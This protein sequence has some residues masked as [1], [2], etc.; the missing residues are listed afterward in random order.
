[1]PEPTQLSRRALLRTAAAASA[2]LVAGPVV[3]TALTGTPAAAATAFVDDYR[4][5]VSGNVT[6]ETNAAVRILAG[7]Q[8]LWHTG[9]AWNTGTVLDAPALHA[10][11]RY[12]I[13]VTRNRTD[14]QAARAFIQDRQ[15]QSYAAISGLGPL[16]PV[17]KAGAL[18]VTSITSAPAGTPPTKIDDAV[19]ADAPPGSALGA[20]SPTSALGQVVTLVNTI[21]GSYSSGNPSKAAYQY[22]RPWRMNEHSVVA[23][24]GRVDEFGFPVYDSPVVVDARLLRQRSTTPADDAGYPSGHTNAFHLAA[25]ALAYA[26]PERFQELVTA[27]FD[28]AETRIVAGMHSPVDVIGG[29]ILATALAA[30]ILNDPA[31]AAVKTAARDQARTYLTARVG[32]D[33]VRYA[34][35]GDRTSD[36]YLDHSANERMVRPKLTYGLPRSRERAAMVV[37]KGAEVLLETRQPYL[38]AAQRREV[39]RTT[40]VGGGWSL[41]DGP[42]QWGRLNVFAAADGYGAFDRDVLVSM[43]PAAGGF[44]AADIWRNDIGGC[45]A[46]VKAGA[47]ALT[48]T[49]AN[50]YRG[51]TTVAAGTLV[52]ASPHALGRG[53]VAVRA[54]SL[55]VASELRITGDYRHFAGT[56]TVPVPSGQRGARL[57]I[58]GDAVLLGGTLQVSGDLGRDLSVLRARRVRGR[59]DRVVTAA[60]V[61]ATVS[62]SR[63]AVTVRLRR[64]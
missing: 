35:S 12:A 55:T 57:L 61:K 54:G 50:T 28:L 42:E 13:Q 59:F 40:A 47:G 34:H 17:Y 56:L 15:H 60:G 22:P 21:R 7:M 3:V 24:T 39:L 19:P 26:I 44:A 31:N 48:L 25:L 41:L 30:A 18:A 20:G 6:T 29:R 27:A 16:E 58:I 2:G 32:P 43:D 53:A 1:M 52:A 38:S 23:D 51:G 46:L 33:L 4:T 63:T 11:M 45:G 62:Y 14:E 49:G 5:N 64:A 36:P 37:P 9:P 10:S 8:R